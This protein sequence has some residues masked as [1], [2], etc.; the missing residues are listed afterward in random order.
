MYIYRIFSVIE[1]CL[2]HI[3]INCVQILFFALK[4][5]FQFQLNHNFIVIGE[6]FSP[7]F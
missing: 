4:V 2:F 3:V 1:Y 6:R 5:T 7:P